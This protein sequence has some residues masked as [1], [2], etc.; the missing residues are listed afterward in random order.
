MMGESYT[1]V[2]K[3]SELHALQL[4][5]DV[6]IDIERR[7]WQK[8][9]KNKDWFPEYVQTLSPVELEHSFEAGSDMERLDVSNHPGI[10]HSARPTFF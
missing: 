2:K 1:R 10:L 8:Q 5:A 4:R 7:F 3:Q 6:I 9:L